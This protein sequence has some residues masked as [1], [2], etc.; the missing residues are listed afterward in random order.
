MVAFILVFLYL[1]VAICIIIAC[2][3]IRF[4]NRLGAVLIAYAVGLALGSVNI[5]PDRFNPLVE[6]QLSSACIILA[7]PLLLFSVNVKNWLNLAGK[8]LLALVTGIVSVLVIIVSGYFIFGDQIEGANKISGML[9]GVYTG[10]TMNL[11]ALH[12]ALG[13]DESVFIL[14]NSFDLLYSSF[15]LFFLMTVGYKLFRKFLPPFKPDGE[16][17]EKPG[18]NEKFEHFDQLIKKKNVL[19]LLAA[20][21]VAVL[22]LG[23]A[24]S[25]DSFLPESIKAPVI[26]LVITTMGIALSFIGPVRKIRFTFDLGMFFIVV[27]SLAVASLADI[28]EIL[29]G[30]GKL[31]YYI[32]IVVF[33]SLVL[34]VMLSKIFKVDADTSVITTTAL[35]CSPPFVPMIAGALKNREVIIPGL[36]IGIIGFAIGNYL[37]VL[38]AFILGRF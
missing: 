22:I 28:Q 4:F 35:I 29:A 25:L 23:V 33:G 14:M 18:V 27:F 34:H 1:L 3:K 2:H 9:V 21:G 17:V 19:P 16:T 37:G 26:I 13:I 38:L 30:F 11:A 5:I 31:S 15:F 36:T 24:L 6:G 32:G 10:G 20:L 8:T 7:L 12:K